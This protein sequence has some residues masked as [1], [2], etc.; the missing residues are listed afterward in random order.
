MNKQKNFGANMLEIHNGSLNVKEIQNRLY[1]E[2][3]DK[4]L[5]ALILFIGI[6]RDEDDI[7][8]LSFDIYEPILKKWFSKWE[9]KLQK[10]GGELFM[11][12]SLGDVL[13]HESSFMCAICSPKRRVSLEFID[14]FVE[15]FKANAP[16]WKYD[17]KNKKRIFI[18]KRGM[19]LPNSGV[20]V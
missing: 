1:D 11:A 2:I 13:L 20:L 17:L 5:G 6:V 7:D 18:K 19:K 8:G 10:K 12:H 16:I 15:D 14:E 3:K 4:N 9:E